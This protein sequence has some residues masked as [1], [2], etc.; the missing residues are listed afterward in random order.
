MENILG[1]EV[2]REIYNFIDKNPGLYQN[3][4]SRQ[5]SIPKSTLRYHFKC[6][7]KL[8][9][10]ETK[11][12]GKCKQIYTAGKMSTQDKQIL[13]L[14][15][16]E[17]SCK[18]ILYLL[19]GVTC[20]QMDLS[21]ELEMHPTTIEFHLKKLLYMDII[22]PAPIKNGVVQRLKRGY[23]MDRKPIT[24]EI[25]YR[26]KSEEIWHAIRNLI[27]T[28]K[29]SLPNNSIIRLMVS[30]VENRD[31]SKDLP[32]RINSA[33]GAVDSIIETI[34]EIFPHPYHA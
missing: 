29:S 23:F 21:K 4:I 17:T 2:R 11:S 27:I 1:L 6:L 9:L 10:I 24:S 34:F 20:S 14:L 22:E 33:N 15:R 3:E 12:E 13:G 16:Q 19:L 32:K 8:G 18:I 28:Q 30:K 26:L 5:M 7:K 31:P 25:I